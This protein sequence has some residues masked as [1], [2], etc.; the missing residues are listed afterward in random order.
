MFN[1]CTALIWG[2][3]LITNILAIPNY[4]DPQNIINAHDSFWSFGL[5]KN[6]IIQLR[7][8][9]T[10]RKEL[11][12]KIHKHAIEF[13]EYATKQIKEKANNPEQIDLYEKA[14]SIVDQA[15]QEAR[16]ILFPI[17]LSATDRDRLNTI[18]N[19]T[20]PEQILQFDKP[21]KKLLRQLQTPRMG[22]SRFQEQVPVRITLEKNYNNLTLFLKD[23]TE[24]SNLSQK[25]RTLIAHAQKSLER[26]YTAIHHYVSFST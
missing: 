23:L 4:F 18:I 26:A 13:K 21:T 24:R 2:I 20:T 1:K 3:T 8:Y 15:E 11:W 12:S 19:G 25:D 22:G 17:G 7:D 10:A 6:G 14:S 16:S 9:P 5:T